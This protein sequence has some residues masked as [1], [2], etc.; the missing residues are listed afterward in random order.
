MLK[1]KIKNIPNKIGV[2]LFLS[3]KKEVL[4]VGKSTRLKS[5]INS[6]FK[7]FS[8]K[9]KLL[10]INSFYVD[11]FL[12]ESEED[13][14]FLE[15]NL[16]KKNQPKYNVLLKDDKSYPWIC[17]KD[18]RFPRVFISK[19]KHHN[20]D[21]YFGPFVNKKS[22]RILYDLITGLYKV[23]YCDY[24]LSEENISKKKYKVCL[25]YHIKKCFGP[26]VGYQK[27]DDYNRSIFSIKKILQGRYSFV[28]KSLK[29]QLKINSDNLNFEKCE[30]I[31]N[32][33]FSL[34][35]LKNKSFI[36]SK[37]N[38]DVDCFYILLFKN[39]FYVNYI[40]VV[41]GC[42]VFIKN[43]KVFN[44][45]FY[46]IDFVLNSFIKKIHLDFNSLFNNILSNISINVFL[47]VKTIVPK[48]GY[49]K[50]IIDFSKKNLLEFIKKTY[51]NID[52]LNELKD[53]LFLKNIPF[54][55]DCFDVSNL[56]GTNTTSSCVVFKNK[57]PCL[58][59]YRSFIIN[60]NNII[61]DYDSLSFAIKKKYKTLK[62][63]PDLIIIDGGIGQLN[64]AIKTIKSLGFINVDIISIAKK[65]EII[66]IENGSEIILSKKNKYLN[67]ICFI[68]DEA[69]R[70]CLKHHR[71]KRKNNFIN[72]ELLKLN[73]IGEKTIFILL[74]SFKSINNIKKLPLNKIVDLIGYK[75]GIIIYNYFN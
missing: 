54:H 43:Y 13:A 75:K 64:A 53:L 12:L 58:K 14:L 17:V 30:I 25:D 45:Y 71:I 40:R 56:S 70:F 60:N 23:R 33:I 4:Y 34:N 35:K 67:Y 62:N 28:L 24:N 26:C 32:Q 20:S 18:E 65:N 10:I 73:G 48:K 59:D 27:E 1:N 16:I 57:K 61:N 52:F 39:N 50:N 51:I 74:K 6:Y 2:Y 21:L 19:K 31:K 38:I 8:K 7:S 15:N 3:K 22:L 69:H 49:K 36:I 41:E 9:H 72:S 63:L 46:T 29:K 55:I 44:K 66:Y 11:F 68:R 5:R 37:K 42:V 47:D